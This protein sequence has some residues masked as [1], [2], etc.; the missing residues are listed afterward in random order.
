MNNIVWLNTTEYSYP[1]LFLFFTGDVC[2]I[3]AYVLIVRDTYKNKYVGIPAGAVCANVAWEFLW[4]FIVHP[5]M[6]FLLVLGYYGW[7]LLDV[8]IVYNT[9]R[10]GH[11]QVQPELQP[12]FKPL[13]GFGVL[14]WLVMI[15]CF[16]KEGHDDPIGATSAYVLQ[17]LISFTY[18]TLLLRIDRFRGKLNVPVSWL[19]MLGS[20]F[21]GIMCI[22]HWPERTWMI[23]M[24]VLFM[25]L[26]LSFLVIMYQ[27]LKQEKAPSPD[28][29]AWLYE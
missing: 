2:W 25:I 3:I 22:M 4:S 27:K 9:F 7:F 17:M 26:D 29:R 6:G 1:E 21:I 11:K 23:S 13:F 28:S 16:I 19:R 18:L 24:I 14:A 12:Y 5:N 10:Y 15:Y 8:L 20:F